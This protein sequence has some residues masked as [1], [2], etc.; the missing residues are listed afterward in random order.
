M[1]VHYVYHLSVRRSFAEYLTK[2]S[3]SPALTLFLHC[4]TVAW[5]ILCNYCSKI[6]LKPQCPF[7]SGL[8]ILFYLWLPK[9]ILTYFFLFPNFLYSAFP[10]I[11]LNQRNERSTRTLILHW[12]KYEDKSRQ[13]SDCTHYSSASQIFYNFSL[14]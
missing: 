13:N 6:S 7:P 1:K 2:K 8:I 14:F 11:T 5:P 3:L 12:N 9:S 10:W 4:N